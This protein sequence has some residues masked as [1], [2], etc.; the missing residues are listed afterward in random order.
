MA[1]GVFVDRRF[2][3]ES[4]GDAGREWDDVGGARGAFALQALVVLHPAISG[5]ASV[6][7]LEHDLDAVDAAVALIDEG[8]VVGDAR[9]SAP[10]ASSAAVTRRLAHQ[11]R[12]QFE[13]LQTPAGD[14]KCLSLG[15]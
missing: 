11:P 14:E 4:E 12:A 3:R 10:S 2:L 6:A 9:W 15:P 5:I 8:V 13:E 1:A 7:F